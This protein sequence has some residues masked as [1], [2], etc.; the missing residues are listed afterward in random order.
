MDDPLHPASIGRRTVARLGV[1]STPQLHNIAC[2]VFN[3]LL[4]FNKIGVTQP[5]F[6]TG[7]ETVILL[8][9]LLHEIGTLDIYLAREGYRPCSRRSILR[10]IDSLEHFGLPFGIVNNG[11]LQRVE[12]RHSPFGRF[13]QVLPDTELKQ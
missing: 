13:V 10:I 1:V 2:I 3:N 11:N 6:G 8:R 12:Y 4:A 5:Y 7:C 9:R